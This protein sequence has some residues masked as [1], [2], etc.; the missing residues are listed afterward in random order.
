MGHTGDYGRVYV[1]SVWLGAGARAGCVRALS[2]RPR[3]ASRRRGTAGVVCEG[4]GRGPLV[5]LDGTAHVRRAAVGYSSAVGRALCANRAP[6]F[7]PLPRD[8]RLVN[9]RRR[10]RCLALLH[11][12][13]PRQEGRPEVPECHATEGHREQ[14]GNCG[15]RG[16]HQGWKGSTRKVAKLKFVANFANCCYVVVCVFNTCV[17]SGVARIR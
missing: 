8:I 5:R 14:E 13:P 6:E 7:E 2:T 12:Q 16:E 4:N 3:G 9:D 10:H 17:L 1:V 15:K 11:G